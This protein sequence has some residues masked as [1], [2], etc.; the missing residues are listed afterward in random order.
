MTSLRYTPK[1]HIKETVVCIVVSLLLN[2]VFLS[3]KFT[4]HD[5][6]VGGWGIFILVWTVVCL[7]IMAM[8]TTYIVVKTKRVDLTSNPHEPVREGDFHDQ[9]DAK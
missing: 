3:Q 6:K 5:D 9:A 7:I 8:L 4:S 1:D 2:I